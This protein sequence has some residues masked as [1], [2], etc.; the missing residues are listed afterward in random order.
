MDDLKTFD[1][2]KFMKHVL[3]KKDLAAEIM[4]IFFDDIN[5]FMTELVKSTETNDFISL[6][7]NAHRLKGS[8]LNVSAEKLSSLFL[9]LE[10]IGKSDTVVGAREV[11][12]EIF[13]ELEKFKYYVS[14]SHIFVNS[15]FIY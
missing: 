15:K 4:R 11:I 12:F 2:G 14:N 6:R 1:A 5:S 7:K 9:K 8:S 10:N 3:N 13:A